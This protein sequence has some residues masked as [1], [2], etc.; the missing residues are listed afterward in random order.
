MTSASGAKRLPFVVFKGKGKTAEDRE[1]KARRDIVVAFSDNGWFNKELT[2]DWCQ[3]VMGSMALGKRLLVWDS[4]RCHLIDSVTAERR[5]KCILSAVILGGC[6]P[7]ASWNKPFKSSIRDLYD[8]WLATGDKTYTAACN[9]RAT[10]KSKLCDII[11]KSWRSLSPDLIK[12]SFTCCGQVPG[13]TVD[14]VSCF[15]DGRP[16]ADGRERLEEF[17]HIAACTAAASQCCGR[18]RR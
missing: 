1:L 16:A 8:E 5:Q 6:T 18:V 4:Y 9:I 14:Q 10:T 17:F 7:L 3:R 13:A 12:N 2:I 15:K 11:V